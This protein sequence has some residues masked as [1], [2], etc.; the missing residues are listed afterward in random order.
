[1][2]AYFYAVLT[3]LTWGCVPLIEKMGLV[4]LPPLVG[5]FYRCLGVIAGIVLLL[6]FKGKDI[7]ASMAELHTGMLFLVLGGF[8]ASVVG[9]LFFYHS[10]KHGEASKVVPLAATYPLVSFLLGVILLGE[11]VTAVKVGG[12]LCILAGVFLLK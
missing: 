7:R 12:L 9:Q 10:L 2:S 1:M 8:L 5:L 4:K 6:L 3:A 11:K